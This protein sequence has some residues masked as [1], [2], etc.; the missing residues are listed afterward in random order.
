[1]CW[2]VGYIRFIDLNDVVRYGMV[3]YVL[4]LGDIILKWMIV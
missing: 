4:I 3:L 2:R 1:M